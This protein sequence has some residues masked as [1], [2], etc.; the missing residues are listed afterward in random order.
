MDSSSW[1]DRTATATTTTSSTTTSRTPVPTH[2]TAATVVSISG[3][4][5]RTSRPA[6]DARQ[7]RCWCGQ[8]MDVVHGTHCPRCGTIRGE[9][10]GGAVLPR[11]AA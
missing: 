5:G 10:R 2:T 4:S 9:S 11:L 3:T 8:D 7:E 1:T 6:A